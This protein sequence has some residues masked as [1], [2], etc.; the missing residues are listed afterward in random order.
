MCY[1]CEESTIKMPTILNEEK[2][3]LVKVQDDSSVRDRKAV[4]KI[5]T[6]F[7]RELD[8]GFVQYDAKEPSGGRYEPYIPTIA[9][10]FTNPDLL[11]YTNAGKSRIATKGACCFRKRAYQDMTEPIWELDWIW[12][13]PYE[14][15][16]GIL[17]RYW[18]V[19]M[20]EFEMFF[21]SHPISKSMEKFLLKQEHPIYA[22]DY[23]A[24]VNKN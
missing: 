23:F 17:Q 19:F 4:E 14:R 7:R 21:P 3:G 16:K 8:Y 22:K 1:Q 13:H 10:L 15:N 11:H 18:Q 2:F 5:A 6:F 20:K 12:L 24:K 9:Y